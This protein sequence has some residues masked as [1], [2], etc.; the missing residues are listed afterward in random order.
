MHVLNF[1]RKWFQPKLRSSM[2]IES[3]D[4]EGG[5]KGDS[6]AIRCRND[7]RDLK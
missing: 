1:V 4:D 7:L 6:Q 5:E 2:K 3:C